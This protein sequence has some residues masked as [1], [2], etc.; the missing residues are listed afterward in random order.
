MKF[1]FIYILS[2]IVFFNTNLSYAD[3]PLTSI[4][5]WK[6]SND[7]Y[8][9]RIG[10]KP[11]KQKLDKQMFNYL[12]NPNNS[13]FEKFALINAL[14]WEFK[15]DIVNSKKFIEYL[16]TKNYIKDE[17]A[18]VDWDNANTLNLSLIQTGEEYYMLYQYMLAMDNYFDV[19]D[20]KKSIS[21]NLQIQKEPLYHFIY[22][23]ISC[24]EM[25]LNNDFCEV[26]NAFSLFLAVGCIDDEQLKY[27]AK[28]ANS[29]ISLYSKSCKQITIDLGSLCNISEYTLNNYQGL[30]II[31]Y[32][33]FVY[34]TLKV[35]DIKN[36]LIL[37]KKSDGDD[38]FEI[39]KGLLE[40]GK[41]TIILNE[42]KALKIF[43]FT[44]KIM[45][46]I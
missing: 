46:D 32:P 19:S 1:N 35:Y 17:L 30:Y 43:K 10:N 16:K 13:T 22:S 44:L 29:Y 36:N 38:L 6:N 42:D 7:S 40:K 34:G 28:L 41:Y 21:E 20:I 12:M 39:E 8:V 37:E 3:S 33:Y 24:Q 11:G 27:S 9:L 5:F 15:S 23:L 2:I 14:K 25:I 4:S 18:E 26:Y 31:N 45:D